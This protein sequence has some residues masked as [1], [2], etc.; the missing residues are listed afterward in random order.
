M[1]QEILTLQANAKDPMINSIESSASQASTLA[2]QFEQE[3]VR[4]TTTASELVWVHHI[5]TEFSPSRLPST[6]FDILESLTSDIKLKNQVWEAVY[7]A[8]SF[9]EENRDETL[10]GMDLTQ[11]QAIVYK[12]HV[13]MERVGTHDALVMKRLEHSK[14]RLEG[15]YSVIRDVRNQEMDERHWIK[16]EHKMQCQFIRHVE[17]Q[18]VQHL[19]LPLSHLLEIDAISH[20]SVIHQVSEEATAE[21]AIAKSFDQVLQTWETREIPLTSLKDRDGRETNSI[22]DCSELVTLLEESEVLLR[23]MECSTFARVIQT[24]LTKLLTDLSHTQTS[25]EL[26]GIGQQQWTSLQRLISTDILRSFPDA[27]KLYQQSEIQWRMIIDGLIKKPLCF[28]FGTSIEYRNTL[29]MI[30]HGFEAILKCLDHHFEVCTNTCMI[31]SLFIVSCI[32]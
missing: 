13:L 26:L 31:I 4:L 9:L 3:S 8:E 23:V 11:L 27:A 5:F 29:E 12:M 32:D 18:I 24:K 28:P 1:E 17:D 22:G 14:Q 15:L 10:R 20:A 30:L 16:L 6:Q 19:E 7:D 2:Y 21:A 25:I